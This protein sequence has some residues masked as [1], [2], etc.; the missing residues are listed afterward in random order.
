MSPIDAIVNTLKTNTKHSVDEKLIRSAFTF[1]EKAHAGQ[2]RRSGEP[3]ITHPL[4]IA[5]HLAR[6]K[7]DSKTIAAALLHD[8]CEDTD[9]SHEEIKKLFGEEINFLV[10]GVTKVNKLKYHGAERT[11]ENLRKMF[12]AIAE[13][14]RVV[15]IK[16]VD[17][18][19]NMKTLSALPEAKQKRI[20]LETLDIYAPLSYRLGIGEL[21]GQL[22]DLAFPYVYPNEYQWLIKTIKTPFEERKKYIESIRPIL[23]TELKKEKIKFVSVTARAKH[24]YSLY[25]KLIKYDMDIGKISDL[26]AIRVTVSSIEDCYAAL[27]AIHKLWRPVPGLIKDY[28]AL[29]K[30]NG[31]Q[32]IHTTIF[33]PEGNV[34]E[35]Q[36]RTEAMHREAEYGIAAHWAYSE[37]KHGDAQSYADRKSSFADKKELQWV[38]QLHDWH[39]AGQS[40]EEFLEAIKI[41]FFKNRIFALTPKG[42]V[43]D[44]P[45]GATPIDFAYHIHSDIGHEAM[46]ATVNNRI[47]PLSFALQNG[48]VVEIITRKNKNPNAD[49]LEIVKTALAR[50]HIQSKL[51]RLS[52]EKS[53]VLKGKRNVEIRF[54]AKDRVGFLKDVSNVMERYKINMDKIIADN[55]NSTYPILLV[56][57]QVKDLELL[58]KLIHSLK[59]IKGVK[60]VEYKFV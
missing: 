7:M 1:A 22:E 55:K 48:E 8:V 49:W 14:I 29:P 51:K 28:I 36:I 56:Y 6:L 24:L 3:Y 45:E 44:L 19:H 53:F 20:A 54:A 38:R 18:L 37:K 33:G 50:K 4:A 10:E 13:D 52:E 25:K 57:C 16:L 58:K 46:G 60:E 27:G 11:S 26:V 23:E 2:K 43:I 41:D 32:S 9:I 31:Y 17:R 34:I 15:I 5:E 47:V 59:E 30:P 39:D 42:D 35:F 40:P 12:L 21:K